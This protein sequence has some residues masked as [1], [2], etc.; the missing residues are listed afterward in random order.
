MRT[1][2]RSNFLFRKIFEIGT[3]EEEIA[4]DVGVGSVG[5]DTEGG[6]FSN[7]IGGASSGF[8][9]SWRVAGWYCPKS[10]LLSDRIKTRTMMA[11]TTHIFQGT[12]WE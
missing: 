1:P 9:G 2:L 3:E 11:V 8:S 12:S 6:C 5:K 4:R 7:G 10:G